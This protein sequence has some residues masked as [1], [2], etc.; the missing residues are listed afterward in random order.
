SSEQHASTIKP[1]TSVSSPPSPFFWG[2]TSSTVLG[3]DG[4][5]SPTRSPFSPGAR[6]VGA[7]SWWR[8]EVYGDDAAAAQARDTSLLST[9]S[10]V[11]FK[12]NLEAVPN[13]QTPFVDPLAD[14]VPLKNKPVLSSGDAGLSLNRPAAG[15]DGGGS[16]G[17]SGSSANGANTGQSSFIDSAPPSNP[18]AGLASNALA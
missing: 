9:L 10:G 15:S 8:S 11:Q 16:T 18:F 7:A 17:G 4:A 2:R 1:D 3:N 13:P 6:D 12:P 14:F 5:N